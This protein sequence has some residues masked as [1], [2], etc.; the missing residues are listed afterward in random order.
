MDKNFEFGG[1]KFQ[2]CKIDAFKQ[3]HIVRRVA[4]MLNDM[5]PAITASGVLKGGVK[6]IETLPEEQ[7]L[8]LI[9]KFISP[10][11]MGLSKLTDADTEVVMHGLLEA[12][13]VQQPT[14][15]WAKVS[16]NKMLMIQDMELPML[17]NIAGRAFMFNIS[18]FF[19]ALPQ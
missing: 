13:E 19:S 4:P 12:V 16:S 7:K 5:L 11:M 15:N 1:R 17:I 10:I 9:A 3:L 2:L 14:G 18:R 6:E 8:D